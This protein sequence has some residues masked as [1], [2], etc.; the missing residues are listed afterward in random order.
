MPWLH[1]ARPL[2]F[3]FAALLGLVTTGVVLGFPPDPVWARGAVMLG[4]EL[5]IA[6]GTAT[7]IL[8]LFLSMRGS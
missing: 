3:T 5:G 4:L 2:T 7:I 6:I 1:A 8:G